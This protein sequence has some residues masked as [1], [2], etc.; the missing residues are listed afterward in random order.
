MS[1]PFRLNPQVIQMLAVVLIALAVPLTVVILG[2]RQVSLRPSG[3]APEIPELRAS[4]EQVADQHLRPSGM[5][6][7]GAAIVL[8]RSSAELPGV[9]RQ[10]EVAAAKVGGSVLVSEIPEGGVR[11]LVKVPASS[12]GDFESSA[13]SQPPPTNPGSGLYEIQILPRP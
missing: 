3:P 5:M 13:L 8:H 12:A 1:S 2:L 10:I 4:L 6:M 9:R 11:L 7:A